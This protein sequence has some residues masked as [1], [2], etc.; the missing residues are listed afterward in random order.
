[1]RAISSR[2]RLDPE[3]TV[4]AGTIDNEDRRDRL[5]LEIRYEACP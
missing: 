5:N 3:P 4:D 1:M 2:I